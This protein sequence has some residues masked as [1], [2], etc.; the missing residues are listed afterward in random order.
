V[1]RKRGQQQTQP[2]ACG[3]VGK[4]AFH[5]HPPLQKR[6]LH[7]PPTWC[8]AWHAC[9]THALNGTCSNTCGAYTPQAHR[10]SARCCA[11]MCSMLQSLCTLHS[12]CVQCAPIS[13]GVQQAACRLASCTCMLASPA[14]A[15]AGLL[16]PAAPAAVAA[17][18]GWRRCSVSPRCH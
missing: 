2:H 7:T 13:G 18:C 11:S 14:A 5:P 1:H 9:E 4:E 16:L 3:K 12:A 15:V 8:R 6:L 10:A 17:A